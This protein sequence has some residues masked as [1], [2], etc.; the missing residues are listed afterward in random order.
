MNGSPNSVGNG[1]GSGVD[2][3][4]AADPDNAGSEGQAASQPSAASAS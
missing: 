2:G 3:A 4:A 1:V